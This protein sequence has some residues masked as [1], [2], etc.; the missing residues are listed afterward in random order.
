VQDVGDVLVAIAL[1]SQ[2][3]DPGVRQ[4]VRRMS[5]A[6]QKVLQMGALVVREV[7]RLEFAHSNESTKTTSVHQCLV[8]KI[9]VGSNS[10]ERF[11]E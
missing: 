3:Y 9:L 11:G 2:E 10:Y 7:D 5:T 6:C 8:G 1:L 4:Q